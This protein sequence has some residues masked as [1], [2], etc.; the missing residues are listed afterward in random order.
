MTITDG[1]ADLKTMEKRIAKK[2]ESILM[3]LVR[4]DGIK[5]PLEKDGGSTEFIRRER[6][7]MADL[8]KRHVDIRV[9]IQKTNQATSITIDGEGKTIAEWLT[10][11]KEVAPGAQ[12]F[13]AKLRLGLVQQ[14]TT[15]TTKGWGVAQPGV[16]NSAL[17]LVINIDELELAKEL[18]HFETVLGTLDG[19][20]SLLNATTTIGID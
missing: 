19:K 2:R 13:L 4:Q 1:L 8:E 20:L 17:A 3:Y 16:D 5:D 10:W 15:A 7:A 11:R 9:A 18:E 12:A 6:Q 14:K